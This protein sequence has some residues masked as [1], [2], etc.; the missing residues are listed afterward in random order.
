M[1]GKRKKKKKKES[2]DLIDGGFVSVL[3]GGDSQWESRVFFIH[4]PFS[5]AS[6]RYG[7]I[8]MKCDKATRRQAEIICRPPFLFFACSLFSSFFLLGS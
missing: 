3:S 4:S 8:I 6:R 2:P 1:G 7:W 5:T